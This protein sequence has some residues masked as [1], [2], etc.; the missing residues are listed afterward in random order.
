MANTNA[1]DRVNAVGN[2][3]TGM[4]MAEM[5][6]KWSS[7]T[8][9]QR[10][11]NE[12]NF[13]RAAKQA[14]KAKSLPKAKVPQS[15]ADGAKA[16]QNKEKALRNFDVSVSGTRGALRKS[17]PASPTVLRR[18][19][20]TGAAVDPRERGLKKNQQDA[21]RTKGST[22]KGRKNIAA[23]VKAASGSS[24]RNQKTVEARRR[25]ARVAG[26]KRNLREYL[27]N[28]NKDM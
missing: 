1:S 6:K 27:A 3:F 23:Q 22:S 21:K 13:V 12:S 10:K 4:S 24:K 17:N 2:P 26:Q 25:R 19:S 9:A 28:K 5:K 16:A 20:K 11:A 18:G 8:P 14:P 7:M 15:S